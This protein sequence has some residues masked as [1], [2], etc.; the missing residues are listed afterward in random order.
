MQTHKTVPIGLADGQPEI[1]TPTQVEAFLGITP[2]Q[3]KDFT[4]AGK[5]PCT[6]LSGKCVR[7]SKARLLAFVEGGK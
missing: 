3:L 4:R 2:R 7:Y 5:L 6:R 1:L